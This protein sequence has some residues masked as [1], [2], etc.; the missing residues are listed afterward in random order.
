MITPEIHNDLVT[1]GLLWIGATLVACILF[2]SYPL[3]VKVFKIVLRYLEDLLVWVIAWGIRT[4]HH[5]KKSVLRRRRERRMRIAMEVFDE[6]AKGG[7]RN[8]FQN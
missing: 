1:F 6:Y 4:Y 2:L 3:L 5:I 8:G 7:A